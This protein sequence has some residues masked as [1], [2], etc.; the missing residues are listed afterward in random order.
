MSGDPD[1][2]AGE[3]G[4]DD[5]VELFRSGELS[6]LEAT[7]VHLARIERFN[8]GVN[9]Y[10]YVDVEG[11]EAAARAS[12]R[13]WR[14][15]RPASAVD[16]V[17][18]S[19]KDLTQ[20][21][22]M[23]AREGSLTVS[24]EPCTDDSPPAAMLR[25]AGAVM[26]GKTNS[27][28]FGW[29]TV[30]DNRVYG[31][32]RNPWNLDLTPG[33]SS[34]GA[35]VAAA[36]NMGVLHQ[37]GDSGGSIRIPAAFTGVF[38]FKPTFGWTPQWP[39]SKMAT[40]SHLGPLTRSVRDA[41]TMLNVIGRYDY[42]D[43]FSRRG[44]PKDWGSELGEGIEGMRIAFSPDCGYAAVD[45]DVRRQVA[46]AAGTLERLGARLEYVGPL[47][48]DPLETFRVMWF[49]SSQALVAEMTDT[50]RE[51][52]DPG[53]VDHARRGESYRAID[54]FNALQS[55][56]EL[57]RRMEHLFHEYDLLLTPSV[58]ITA[59][60][61]GCEVPPGSDMQD[62]ME[63]APFSYPFNL[64]Q[65]PA[66]SIPCGFAGDGLPVGIQLAG[67]MFDD[68]RVLRACDAY[69]REV[70]PRFPDGSEADRANSTRADGTQNR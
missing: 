46:D 55:R 24:A 13:R 61:A 3:L 18:V 38:G 44:Q 62:W 35:A 12:E 25:E 15:G 1:P 11:A 4:V 20:V 52:L 9:A 6:P 14:E 23:P 42:R 59:F 69:L 37:S 39:P 32:T 7:R 33:G 65:Q 16:G 56:A 67:G 17:P 68:T 49:T 29:K 64:T 63:W 57:T 21:R 43:P 27:P 10:T 19:I 28:E 48:D 47:F 53:L 40:L 41:A 45:D 36:L 70:P 66:A 31:T 22:G 2:D 26:L 51:Q 50:Q 34:G 60:E 5:L 54:F 30:T 58:P 8:P